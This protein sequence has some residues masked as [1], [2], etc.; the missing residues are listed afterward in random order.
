MKQQLHDY[1]NRYVSFS[2]EELNVFLN[3]LKPESYSKK[4]FLVKEGDLCKHTYF[5]RSG[6]IRIFRIDEKGNEKI[7]H[8]GV[9]NWWLTNME[10]FILQQPSTLYIQA[11]EDT[12]VLKIS[13]VD[14][15][16][17]YK[18][19]PKLERVFR[20]ITEKMLIAIERKNEYFLKRSSKDRYNDFVEHL[21]AFSQRVPQYMIAS[22]LDITP[23]YLSELRKSR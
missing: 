11:L 3:F 7:V 4:E 16:K 17:A 2:E 19:I 6:L 21:Q 5:I 12:Q 9:E 10:S 18:A 8:F 22:Y 23:E 15:D 13:K 20:L 14:L 1:L